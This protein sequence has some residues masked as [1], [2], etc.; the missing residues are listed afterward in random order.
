MPYLNVTFVRGNV[1]VVRNSHISVK[2]DASHLSYAG[3]NTFCGL[4]IIRNMDIAVA[5]VEVNAP[6]GDQLAVIPDDEVSVMNYPING[7]FI[8]KKLGLFLSGLHR[9]VAGCRF[10]LTQNMDCSKVGPDTDILFR[11]YC[12]LVMITIGTDVDISC[13]RLNRYASILGINRLRND[14]AALSGNVRNNVPAS[15]DFAILGDFA[16][17]DIAFQYDISVA[18]HIQTDVVPRLKRSCIRS[19]ASTT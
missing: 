8:G 17:S 19:R 14:D 1:H 5:P 15:G 10:C 16:G 2:V 7:H 6:A 13:F 4:N 12:F 18:V 3:R 11:F 9:D